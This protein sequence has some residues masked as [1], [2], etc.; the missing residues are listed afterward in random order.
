MRQAKTCPRGGRVVVVVI[1][2]CLFQVLLRPLS[3]LFSLYNVSYSDATKLDSEAQVSIGCPLSGYNVYVVDEANQPVPFGS[4]PGQIAAVGSA[5][6]CGYLNNE[7]LSQTKFVP[8]SPIG[9]NV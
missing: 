1:V 7:T 6:S 3:L 8:T 4:W 9:A 2:S 5:V